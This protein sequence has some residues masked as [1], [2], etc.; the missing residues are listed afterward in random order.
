MAVFT[1]DQLA[2]LRTRLNANTTVQT[3]TK[4]QVNAAWQAIEDFM[5][6]TSTQNTL[7]GVIETAAPGGFNTAQKKLLFGV[8]CSTA[9]RRLGV[10]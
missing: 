2:E 6:L 10:Q 7:G 9:A 3:W 4:P 5:M 8:W 1:S